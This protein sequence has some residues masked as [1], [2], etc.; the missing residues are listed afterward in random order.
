MLPAP[1]SRPE[2]AEDL[3]PSS[4]WWTAGL[5]FVAVVEAG[6]WS[7]EGERARAYLHARGL[8]DETLRAWRVGF[9]PEEGRRDP[10]ER[11]GFP[12]RNPTGQPA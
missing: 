9:Q 8:N 11:W 4:A 5:R 10:A 12:A 3:E 7:A 2:L 1:A 6:R